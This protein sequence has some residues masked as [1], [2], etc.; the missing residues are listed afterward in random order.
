MQGIESM[1]EQSGQTAAR[2][3]AMLKGVPRSPLKVTTAELEARLRSEG[4][5]VSRRTIERDLHLLSVQFPLVLDD[6]S[7]PYGW[8]WAKGASFEFMPKLT[9]AQGVAL[10]LASAHLATLLPEAMQKELAPVFQA[11]EQSLAH[12][13]WKDWHRKTAVLPTGLALLPPRI[14]AGTLP[15]IESAVAHRRCLRANYR[16]KG[17]RKSREVVIHPLGLISRGPVMYLVCT[18]FDYEDVRQLALH[19][20]TDPVETGEPVKQP[21]GFDFRQYAEEAAP[22]YL[23][24][25]PIR[26][27]AR[28]DG[29]AA[30]HLGET[31]LSLDQTWKDLP[32]GRVEVTATVEHDETLQWWLMAFGSQVEVIAPTGLRSWMKREMQYSVKK[33]GI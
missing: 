10:L 7:K 14:P 8:S 9:P 11:A 24:R 2:Q 30:E 17:S 29:P 22:R 6:R 28:F 25:G 32:D 1:T 12:S 13:G 26:L 31:P 4:F 5:H 33:Y 27:V 15:R 19:R 16:S 21:K 3:W 18:L 20:I 23:S